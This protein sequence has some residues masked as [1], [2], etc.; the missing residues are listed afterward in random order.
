MPRVIEEDRGGNAYEAVGE[1]GCEGA[2]EGG[3][4][5]IRRRP[6]IPSPC[7]CPEKLGDMTAE[8][9]SKLTRGFPSSDTTLSPAS[10]FPVLLFFGS[11]IWSGAC[12]GFSS[13]DTICR[14]PLSTE[15]V[16]SVNAQR[17]KDISTARA[18]APSWEGPS[19]C[20]IEAAGRLLPSLSKP[21]SVM[22]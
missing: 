21:G 14:S 7:S 2:R 15:N 8:P 17:A 19:E 9:V 5:R 13:L 3:C 4:C 22:L 1:D 20:K 6:D 16:L 11:L 18:F 12:S 10:R